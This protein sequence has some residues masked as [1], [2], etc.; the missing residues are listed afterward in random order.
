MPN[1]FEVEDHFSKLLALLVYTSSLRAFGLLLPC[2]S[3]AITYDN[4][5]DDKPLLQG[6]VSSN[7]LAQK[8][9]F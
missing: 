7:S 8:C 5:Y 1:S 9:A 3:A 6:T 2:A 4:T